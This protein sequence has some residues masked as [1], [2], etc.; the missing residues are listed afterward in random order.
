MKIYPSRVKFRMTVTTETSQLSSSN[1]FNELEIL[2]ERQHMFLHALIQIPYAFSAINSPVAT[3]VMPAAA[4][5][6]LS[7]CYVRSYLIRAPALVKFDINYALR[8]GDVFNRCCLLLLLGK[9]MRCFCH[10]PLGLCNGC[11]F[12]VW[13]RV[14]EENHKEERGGGGLVPRNLSAVFQFKCSQTS[15]QPCTGYLKEY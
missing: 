5:T 14:V 9:K 4:H 8:R 13:Q 6:Y 12:V 3:R 1:H 7:Y 11:L 10:Q 15:L 2:A